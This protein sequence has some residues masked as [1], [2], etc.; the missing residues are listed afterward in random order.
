VLGT[1]QALIEALSAAGRTTGEQIWQLP[2]AAEYRD[3]IKSP[4]A[5]VKNVG[6]GGEGGTIIGALFLQEFV[7]AGIP[8]AHVDIAG[9]AFAERE[10]PHASKGATGYGVRLLVEWLRGLV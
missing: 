8:W 7:D 5:D 6:S 9:P 2:L 4:I 1:D 10:L 3:D